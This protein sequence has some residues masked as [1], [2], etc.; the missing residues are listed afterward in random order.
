MLWR[1]EKYSPKELH[2]ITEVIF[3]QI[4]EDFTFE[5]SEKYE[6]EY[7]KALSNFRKEFSNEKNLWDKFLDVLAG[8]THQTPSES[9]MMQRWLEGEKRDL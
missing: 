1:I 8:G 2:K 5:E 9:V 4:P 3:N 6:E 7:L